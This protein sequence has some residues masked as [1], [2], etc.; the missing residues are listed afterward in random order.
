MKKYPCK[1]CKEQLPESRFAPH[2]IDRFNSLKKNGTRKDISCRICSLKI[3]NKY[4]QPKYI[5]LL[6]NPAWPNYVKIG[7]TKNPQQRLAAYNT[8]SPKRDYKFIFIERV[9]RPTIVEML[10][11]EQCNVFDFEW[12]LIQQDEAIS[13]VKKII[14]ELF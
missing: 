3:E 8:S 12:A 11:L 1:Y 2:M 10:F 9:K 7:V 14:N 5:Y 13:I 4:H 6:I